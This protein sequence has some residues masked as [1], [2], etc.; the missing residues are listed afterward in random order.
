MRAIAYFQTNS[1][2]EYLQAFEE[3]FLD[4]CDR[5]LHQPIKTFADINDDEGIDRFTQYRALIEYMRES[6]SKLPRRDTGRQSYRKRPGIGCP[7]NG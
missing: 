2:Q 5:N 1:G 6:G 7:V 3:A 4:Y